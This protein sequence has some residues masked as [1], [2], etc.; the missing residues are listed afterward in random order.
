[1]RAN[2]LPNVSVA[3]H[4]NGNALPEHHA[5]SEDGKTSLC[6]V[7]AVSGDHQARELVRQPEAAQARGRR[8]HGEAVREQRPRDE[9]LGE[10]VEQFVVGAGLGDEV[11]ELDPR[12]VRAWSDRGQAGCRTKTRIRRRSPTRCR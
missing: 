10:V 2:C 9:V 4:V 11:L 8:E 1:M 3:V 5:D 7:E 6:Y 12:L